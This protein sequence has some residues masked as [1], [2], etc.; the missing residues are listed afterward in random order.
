M[1]PRKLFTPVY[2]AAG[3]VTIW[4]GMVW[5]G[6]CEFISALSQRF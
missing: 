5:C 6:K 1:T 4:Y 2:S 3:E